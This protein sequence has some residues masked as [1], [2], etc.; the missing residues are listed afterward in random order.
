MPCF[1]LG[2]FQYT[3]LHG[4]SRMCK[5]RCHWFASPTS[6]ETKSQRVPPEECH[7]A[8]QIFHNVE[9]PNGIPRFH[10]MEK[11]TIRDEHWTLKET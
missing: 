2:I 10:E 7:G 5:T 6:T 1:D 9:R 3:I 11:S 4:K 8:V